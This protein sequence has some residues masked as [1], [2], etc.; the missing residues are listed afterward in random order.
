MNKYTLPLLACLFALLASCQGTPE[1][2]APVQEIHITDFKGKALEQAQLPPLMRRIELYED[3]NGYIGQIKDLCAIDSS[4]YILDAATSAI[5]RFGLQDGKLQHTVHGQGG[6]PLE[7]ILPTALT[8]DEKNVHVLD[9]P[10]MAIVTYD[11]NLKPLKKIAL[12]ASCSD[13]VRVD[14]GF[15]CYNL[16]PS[17]KLQ[18]LIYIDNEGNV[19]ESF[20]V[21]RQSLPLTTG[22]KIFTRNA[23]KEIFIQPPFSRTVYQWNEQEK[24][25]EEYIRLDFGNKNLPEEM[26]G[27]SAN[28]FDEPYA[29]PTHCFVGKE[30]LLCSFL[31]GN[32]RYYTLSQPGEEAKTGQAVPQPQT[33]FFPQWQIE[34]WAVGTYSNETTAKNLPDAGGEVLL[35]FE[36]SPIE[37]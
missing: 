10:G 21:S 26:S 15:L 8:A 4:L 22:A 25:P 31:Y 37:D 2:H 5:S 35:L 29:I 17:D 3:A 23:H 1:A 13:F 9:L 11:S 34:D 14:G 20:Q 19:R 6:G 16:T 32:E 28:P 7:Y 33:P 30:S 12:P 36:L 18:S 24:R 27:E